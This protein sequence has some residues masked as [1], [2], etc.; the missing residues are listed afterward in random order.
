MFRQLII[1]H[2]GDVIFNYTLAKGLGMEELG[3]VQEMLENYIEVPSPGKT[4]KQPISDHMIYHQGKGNLYFIF[5]A[6]LV[7]K[8][9]YF[10]ESISAIIKKFKTNFPIPETVNESPEERAK[11]VAYLYETQKSLLSKIAIMGAKGAGRSTLFNLLKSENQSPIMNFALKSSIKIDKLYFELWDFQLDD[12]FSLLWSKHIGGS[13]LI[14]FVF[15]ASNYKLKV[16]NYFLDLAKKESKYSK[17]LILANKVDLIDEETLVHIK[18]ELEIEEINPVTLKAPD[19]EDKIKNYIRDALDFKRKLPDN[20]QD[21]RKQAKNLENEENLKS[22]IQKYEELLQIA[23][24]FQNFSY[25]QK[26]EDKLEQLK[27]RRDRQIEL[28]KELKR[29]KKFS[30]P[31]QKKFTGKIKV[32]SLPGA[33]KKTK[34]SQVKKPKSRKGVQKK[35]SPKPKL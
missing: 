24:N 22:A 25:V 6:D 30:A 16:L 29:K 34:K 26:F 11:F 2:K 12:N 9:D 32:K 1:F 15:D 31:D 7:D 17:L 21:L 28:Q 4:F 33:G 8:L 3:K 27:K 35:K 18:N 14:I 13:D 10:Q 20:F 23:N 5:V 19:A